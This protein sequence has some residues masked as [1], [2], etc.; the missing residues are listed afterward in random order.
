VR[1]ALAAWR[2]GAGDATFFM[3][4][5]RPLAWGYGRL[6]A[7]RRLAYRRGW[8]A[9]T[10]LPVRVVSIGNLTVGG[11]GKTPMVI[12]L[13]EWLRAAGWPVGI[14]LRGYR[15]RRARD[16]LLVSDG[17]SVIA[18]VDEAGD[19]AVLLARR[20]PGVPVAVGRRRAEAGR[21]LVEQCAPRLLLIDDGFQHLALRRDVNLLLVDIGQPLDGAA[22]LPA[23]PLREEWSAVRDASAVLLVDRL[24]T[25]RAEEAAPAWLPR[26]RRRGFSGPLFSVRL[27]ASGVIACASGALQPIDALAGARVAICSGVA[28]PS[29]FREMVTRAG[30]SIL[31]EWIFGDHHGYARDEALAIARE[32]GRRGAAMVVTTEKDAVKLTDWPADG[33]PLVA[34]RLSVSVEPERDWRDWL[35]VQ[36]L[37]P[38]DAVGGHEAAATGAAE[39]S[40][41]LL[42]SAPQ[43]GHD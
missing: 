7:L 35:A 20:L 29:A 6:M 15:G 24:G 1:P 27:R 33:P 13:A 39:R 11:S 28:Q 14:V 4:L 43:P 19:E 36:R 22:P 37:A 8:A 23:G 18:T 9:S 31:A 25:G 40:G 42:C 17:R 41:E 26:L 16:P 10:R 3:P 32:A 38:A 2:Y 34:L 30:A 5:L 12:A 21:L